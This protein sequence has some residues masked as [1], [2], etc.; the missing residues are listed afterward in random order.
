MACAGHRLQAD[1]R[2]ALDVRI[3]GPNLTQMVLYGS[4]TVGIGTSPFSPKMF[5]ARRRLDTVCTL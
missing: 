3:V 4:T 1:V 5:G 2:R